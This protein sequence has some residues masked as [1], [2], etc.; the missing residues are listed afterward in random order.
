M[1][2]TL[3]DRDRGQS[4]PRGSRQ[5]GHTEV[6]HPLE[7]TD[8]FDRAL[9]NLGEFDRVRVVAKLER[10]EKEWLDEDVPEADL[11]S[12][13]E[14]KTPKTD[15]ACREMD[16]RQIRPLGQVRVLMTKFDQRQRVF[17]LDVE[18]KTSPA[19]QQRFIARACRRARQLR[20]G[21]HD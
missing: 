12:T 14:Y 8:W 5:R 20:E 3:G 16:L 9:D 10:F 15:R 1:G 19:A 11:R 7:R 6:R 2:A 13:W 4:T 21:R 18:V 17:L